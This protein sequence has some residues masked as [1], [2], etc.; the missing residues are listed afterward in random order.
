M[1]SCPTELPATGEFLRFAS[2]HRMTERSWVIQALDRDPL[3]QQVDERFL[4]DP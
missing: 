3:W 1:A 2:E 4:K